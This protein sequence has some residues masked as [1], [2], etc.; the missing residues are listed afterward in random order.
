MGYTWL[1]SSLYFTLECRVMVRTST[2]RSFVNSEQTPRT[3]VATHEMT[4][5]VLQSSA[6]MLLGR[7]TYD[8]C[9]RRCY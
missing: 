1:A 7:S 4:P 9:A 5:A 3:I 6:T 2:H 8:T